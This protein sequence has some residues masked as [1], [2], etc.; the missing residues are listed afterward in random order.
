MSLQFRWMSVC[1][2]SWGMSGPVFV[3]IISPSLLLGIFDVRKVF[4]N[5]SVY[6][7]LTCV[8]LCVALFR[9]SMLYIGK[10]NRRNK[11]YCASNIYSLQ[12]ILGATI[13][14]RRLALLPDH[15][16]RTLSIVEGMRMRNLDRRGLDAGFN[17]RRC[18]YCSDADQYWRNNLQYLRDSS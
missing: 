16:P 4:V 14:G 8:K 1:E 2:T 9:V 15:Y 5:N 11:N 17:H 12:W 6:C 7:L 13:C 18:E 10:N 3:M